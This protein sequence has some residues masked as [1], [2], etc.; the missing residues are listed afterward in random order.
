MLS[1]FVARAKKPTKTLSFPRLAEEEAALV[2]FH[3]FNYVSAPWIVLP[4]LCYL[5]CLYEIC[6]VFFQE[7]VI[8]IERSKLRLVY[9]RVL[10]YKTLISLYRSEIIFF[11]FAKLTQHFINICYVVIGNRKI[12]FVFISGFKYELFV[13]LY[14][15]KIVFF[16]LIQLKVVIAN[17]SGSI[18]TIRKIRLIGIRVLF[19]EA[20]IY[21]YR[22]KTIFFC[23]FWVDL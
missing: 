9:I 11:C 5:V 21:F 14:C 23:F 22:I 15:S 20:L 10:F 4:A 2:R 12:F 8:I 3:N 13:Y 17:I 18:I 1:L 19:R 6:F 7:I 16:R